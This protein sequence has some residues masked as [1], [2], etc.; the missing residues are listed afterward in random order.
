MWYP[1]DRLRAA[2]AGAYILVPLSMV[3]SGIVTE[4]IEGP[5]GVALDL[6]CFFLNGFGV[7]EFVSACTPLLT[8]KLIM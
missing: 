5:T 8:N 6:A 4:H 2:L 1:E 7:C 3:I